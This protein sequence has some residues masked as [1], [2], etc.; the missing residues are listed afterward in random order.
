MDALQM[1]AVGLV[2]LGFLAAI[3]VGMELL[4]RWQARWWLRRHT[5]KN[6]DLLEIAKRRPAPQE[7]YDE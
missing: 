5:P 2:L 4:E 7:W 1:I 3:N 6:A